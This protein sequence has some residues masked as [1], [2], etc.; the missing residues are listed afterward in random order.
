VILDRFRAT[1]LALCVALAAASSGCANRSTSS[2]PQP[3]P[4]LA[5][6]S[7][8]A[9]YQPSPPSP[10]SPPSQ[11]GQPG[12]YTAPAPAQ[13]W[14][15]SMNKGREDLRLGRL[16]AAE[17]SFVAALGTTRRMR[18][19]DVLRLDATLANLERVA[20]R[21]RAAKRS[22]DFSRVAKIVI[23]ESPPPAARFELARLLTGLGRLQLQD[24]EF[25]EAAASFDRALEI[26]IRLQGREATTVI[27]LNR[28]LAEVEIGREDPDAA[29]QYL[30]RAIEIQETAGM[31]ETAAFV[32]AL[33]AL[34]DVRTQQEQLDEARALS[35]RA[36]E[37]SRRLELER[38]AKIEA[39]L[40]E[41][42]QDD[43]WSDD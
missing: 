11:P 22:D 15:D 23:A 18:P 7:P 37:I 19:N 21:Y 40:I 17:E 43:P 34:A 5:A 20:E 16:K 31:T 12:P 39:Q 2:A 1:L 6:S 14:S 32:D 10:P 36:L 28:M 29:A 27:N 35:G 25:D 42:Q 33:V 4:N 8:A 3:D 41:L 13:S 24:E 9:P 38:S 30:E 26:R